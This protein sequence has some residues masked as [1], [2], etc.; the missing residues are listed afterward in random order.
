VKKLA[1]ASAILSAF[2]LT[3]CGGKAEQP[4]ESTETV[5]SEVAL[6]ALESKVS[7][8]LG[9]SNAKGFIGQG[10][11]LDEAAFIK[12]VTTA[13]AGGESAISDDDAPQIIQE[14]QTKLQAKAQSEYEK[15]GEENRAASEAFLAENATK[16]GVITTESGLQYKV[17]VATEG[18]KPTAQ[19]T[20]QV[21]YEG[22]LING[23]VF[24]SSI[25]RGSPVEF[26]LTQVIAGW[27]EGLQLMPE[28]SKYEFYIP[29]DLAYGPGGSRSI[30]PNEALI[31]VV[32]LIQ[33]NYSAE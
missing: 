11:E 33:A 16:E 3:A 20:V 14:Y 22:R 12:G 9:Y 5:S 18:E 6:E 15:A 27:T 2:I 7:Y 25:E 17:L 32:E 19:S 26:G 30:G 24:D 4:E 23:D 1:F 31:F 28:G 13:I 21:H 29:S 10:V 8:L